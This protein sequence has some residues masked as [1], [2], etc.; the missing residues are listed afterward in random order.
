MLS[1]TPPIF[2]RFSA[3]LALAALLVIGHADAGAAETTR[4]MTPLTGAGWQFF[5]GGD[6]PALPAPGSASFPNLKWSE[7]S[8]PHTFQE[9]GDMG[10]SQ[11]LY[12]RRLTIPKSSTPKRLYLVFEGA[13]TVADVYLNGKHLGQHNGAYTR[14][15][16]DVTREA[17][18]GEDNELVVRVDNRA[19]SITESLPCVA[20]AG[21]PA[22]GHPN[23]RH[24]LYT[25]WGGLYRDVSLLATNDLH[26][27][28]THHAS[29]GVFITPTEVSAKSAKVEV[30]VLLRNTSNAGKSAEVTA[31]VLDPAGKPV[32]TLKGETQV[33]A[34]GRTE[35][36]L[37]DR[38]EN[39]LLWEPGAPNLYRVRV[40]VAQAG[41]V[42]DTVIQPLGFRSMLW[43]LKAGTLQVN[44]RPYTLRGVNLHQ[45]IEKGNYAMTREDLLEDFEVMRDLGVNWV[46]FSHYPREQRAYDLC[47]ERGLFCWAENGNSS[48]GDQ[49][50]K[51][52]AQIT[53]EMVLQNY[54]HPSIAVWSTGNESAPSVA[55]QC[56][57]IVKALD[58]TRPAMVANMKCAN[59]DYH[60]VN[61]YPGWYGTYKSSRWEFTPKGLVTEVGG[62]G[63]VTS[64]TDYA[65]A[66]HKVNTYEP[67]E[68]QQL[69]AESIFELSFRE[70]K[71]KL[72]M[73]T[74]WL[75]REINDTKYK[76]AASHLN[77]GVNSKGLLTFG[78]DKKDTYYLYRC[79][80]RPETPTVWITS[81]RHYL[82]RGSADN[83]VKAY[84]NAKELTLTL[85]GETLPVLR[86]GLYI[87]P[88]DDK[89]KGKG[90]VDNVFHWKT[91]LRLGKNTIVVTDGQ[92]NT[93]TATIYYSPENAPAATPEAS[94]P[95]TNL[96]SSNPANPAYH[97]DMP[98]RAQWPFYHDF[99]SNADN[100]LE[101]IPKEAKGATWISLRR[102][103]NPGAATDLSFTITKPTL[104]QVLCTKKPEAPA[105]I[106]EAGFRKVDT[107]GLMWRG[108]D[109]ILVPAELYSRPTKAGENLKLT[110][111]ERDA[112]VLLKKE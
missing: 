14:F 32:L 103:T 3:C 57:P 73:L 55:E 92:G 100:S 96:A 91:P 76:S 39:P 18:A 99:D 87:Q 63:V 37:S 104:V 74:W 77:Q 102:V 106:T 78:G 52:A 84:S 38:L 51:V 90:K 97:M 21:V 80:L 108:D 107:Q 69:Y 101:L 23:I 94:A 42:S 15:L 29:P 46:R 70:G 43:D 111:G 2:R 81:K 56:V 47:D 95:L 10:R 86:N 54:N 112:L 82:R 110:L 66:K 75:L 5:G 88:D 6:T 19:A 25:V 64:H 12:R 40:D 9:R 27:D 68:Y 17:R 60:G 85:N 98:V 26:V 7:V 58:T 16:F 44:G 49:V 93:D 62:G 83:G 22:P 1:N 48:L 45:E 65:D 30:K 105:Q 35:V 20:F 36:K 71:E 53:T 72:G 79:F 50:G 41:I 89:T 24:A 61:T 59:A 28:P 33:A 11:G 31:T 4:E 8:V 34:D 109:M 67:E 13:S